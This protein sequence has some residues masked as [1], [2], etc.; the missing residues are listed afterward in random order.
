MRIAFLCPFPPEQSGIA[1]YAANFIA[2]LGGCGVDVHRPL[3]A[4]SSQDDDYPT[5]VRSIDWRQ[6]DLVHAELGGGRLREF[7]CL[8]A[9]QHQKPDLPL[10]A[11][12]HDPERLIWRPARLPGALNLT[13]HL[14]RSIYQGSVLLADPWM[15]R[16]EKKLAQHLRQ[17]ITLTQTG[18]DALRARMQLTPDQVAVIPHGNLLIPPAPLPALNTI[19]LLYFGFIY[20]GKGI[21]DLIDALAL[22]IQQHPNLRQRLQLTLAGGTA[23]EMAFGGADDYLGELQK[24]MAQ[25]GISEQ[26]TLNIDVAAEAIPGLIQQHH[27][28]VLPYRESKKLSW[29]GQIRGTS[30]ALAWAAACG[31]GVITSDARAFPEEVAHGNGTVFPQGNIRALADIFLRLAMHPQLITDW[32]SAAAAIGQQRLW[33]TIAQQ[34]LEVFETARGHDCKKE[35]QHHVA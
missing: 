26:V 21:E 33:P 10:T 29:L 7:Y 12:I 4:L 11:T 35:K 24:R 3:Q 34:F 28:M 25:A 22:V 5:F 8:Q 20:R 16:T 30:G 15:L 14:P 17:L 9:L 31:R 1:D 2:A 32:A 23:P 27:V 18:A 13:R 6:F 19:K